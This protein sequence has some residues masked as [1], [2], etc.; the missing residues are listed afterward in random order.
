MEEVV[1]VAV[2]RQDGVLDALALGGL[3]A[4]DE[5]CDD[6]ALTGRIPP[7]RNGALPIAGQH[8]RHPASRA[9]SHSASLKV[10]LVTARP[11]VVSAGIASG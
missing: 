9:A 5:R 6:V 3:P 4:P 10:L 8:I 2:H 1:G 7:E 11:H